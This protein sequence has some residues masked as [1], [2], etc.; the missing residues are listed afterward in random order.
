[1]AGRENEV[2]EQRDKGGLSTRGACSAGLKPI[3]VAGLRVPSDYSADFIPKTRNS[4]TSVDAAKNMD[5][6]YVLRKV[7]YICWKDSIT[8]FTATGHLSH[9]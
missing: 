9:G 2:K 3:T 6:G 4:M 7:L 8:W 1:V 5:A